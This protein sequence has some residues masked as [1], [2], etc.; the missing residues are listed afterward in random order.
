MRPGTELAS[1]L[2]GA[3]LAACSAQPQPA[4]ATPPSL[5]EIGNAAVSGLFEDPVLLSSGRW[6]GEPYVQGGASRPS[7]GLAGELRLTGDLDGDGRKETVVLLWAATGGSGTRNFVGVFDRDGQTIRNVSTASLG[8]RVQVREARV[9]GAQIVLDVVQ[10]GPDDPACCPGEKATR[11]YEL[12]GGTLR[13]LPADAQGRVGIVDLAGVEWRLAR[14][15]PPVPLPE[16]PGITLTVA[17]GRIS[18]KGPCNRYF[19]SIAAGEGT[20]AVRIGQL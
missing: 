12:H 1:C 17:D 14:M 5:G 4:D 11:R 19:G 15:S 7:A 18:G 9:D 2:L 10:Q 3:V 16:P 13:E 20:A 6:A 8:D